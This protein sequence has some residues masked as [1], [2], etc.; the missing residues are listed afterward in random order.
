MGAS[1]SALGET[2][3]AQIF[4]FQGYRFD[5]EVVGDLNQVVSQP[6]D[7]IPLELQSI[8]Y[9]RSPYNVVRLTRNSEQNE[10]PETSYPQAG[11]TLS[12]W[13]AQ[14]ALRQDPL[15]AIYAYAQD[16]E[17]EGE[18]KAQ[19]GFVALLDVKHSGRGVLAHER[20]LSAPKADRLRLMRATECNDDSIYTLYTDDRLTVNRLLA[21][22][23]GSRC[24]DIDVRDDYG[25]RH[26][27]WCLTTPA[28]I[29]A[30]R[31]AMV[32]EELFIADGH[33]RYETSI[34]FMNECEVKG[35]K[36]GG[37]ESFDKRIV[38]CF[39]SAAGGVTILP[40]HRAVRDLPS[41][42]A[43]SFLETAGQLFE[44]VGQENEE[45]LWGAMRANSQ[46]HAFGFA[47]SG[48]EC[49][50]LLVLREEA[51]V[52]PLMLAHG[53]AYRR[54]DVSI[55]HLLL[56]ENLLGIDAA[57]LASQ[58]HVDYL[59]ERKEA[60]QCVR[61][62]RAQ[63]AFFLNPTTVEQVQR[64][65]LLGERMPQKSTDFY[66]KLLTGLVLMKMKIVK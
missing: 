27:L 32:P 56:L 18:K 20:T 31:D 58:S 54:L 21:E 37:V 65:A 59:R 17:I 50:R 55:L 62:G 4:P 1:L 19:I 24:S 43:G 10:N 7:K 51:K 36:R 28:V 66:P 34:S 16:Y 3:M 41:F 57:K 44:V 45:A 40:T 5:P 60:L 46:S 33:H 35:W 53:E 15:P 42:D 8:Y 61:D 49:L 23:T 30:I 29:R 2:N 39:N 12:Q 52:D 6:Y 26:R 13:I 63:C 11:E 25:V 38:T 9:Q 47:A 22:Q 48:G 64:V 14:G